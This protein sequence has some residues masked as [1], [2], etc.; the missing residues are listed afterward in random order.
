MFIPEGF[1]TIAPYFVV[2][3]AEVLIEF[4]K[5]AF[6]GVE[7][8]RHLRDGIIA[9]AQIKIGDSTVMISEANEHSKV[10][11]GSYYLY[12]ENADESIKKAVE[13]GGELLM[14]AVD[15][16]YQDRQGGVKD[17]AGNTWWVSQRLVDEP[18]Y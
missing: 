13:S 4:L 18:Y 17:P 9:N 8:G 5:S 12:V 1:N 3:E 16:D 10:T 15:M 11:Q 14:E 7:V 6:D 2:E